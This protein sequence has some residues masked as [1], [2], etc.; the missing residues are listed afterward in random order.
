MNNLQLYLNDQLVDLSDDSPIALTFQIN[1]LADVKNQQG[2]TSNQ[3]KVPLTQNN[4]RILGFPDEV[5]FTNN[6]PYQQYA[7]KIVQDGLEIV[8]YGIG[9]LNSVDSNTASITILSGNVDFFDAIDQKIFDMGDSTSVATNKG[10]SLPWK[11]YD[12]AWTLQNVVSSQGKTDGWIWPVI[13]Y[14]NLGYN[15]SANPVTVDVRNLR[16]GFFLKTAL[17]LIT[18]NAGYT[19]NP[20]SSLL[21]DPLYEGLIVQFANDSFEHGTDYQN[22]NTNFSCSVSTGSDLVVT[23]SR[24]YHGTVPFS[25][26]VYGGNYFDHGRNYYTAPENISV[27][28]TLVFSAVIEGDPTSQNS[29]GQP[30]GVEVRLHR[31]SAGQLYTLTSTTVDLS[32]NPPLISKHHARY[33]KD[34]VKL[35]YEIVLSKGDNIYVEY[36]VNNRSAGTVTI[37]YGTTLTVTSKNQGI[38]YG[39]MVQCERIFPDINQKDLLKDMLQRFGIICQA[40]NTGKVITFAS[41][42]DIVSNIPIAKDWTSKCLDQGKSI[43][44]QL[45]NYAQINYMKYKQ[46]DNVLPLG[47]ADTQINIA[48]QTL[49]ATTE[50]FTSQFAGTLNRAFI[51]GSAAQINKVDVSSDPSATDFTIGTQ[52]RILI[53]EKLNLLGTGKTVRFTDGISHVDVN[54]SISVPYFS[55][56]NGTYDLRFNALRLKYYAELEK[57]LKQTKKVVRYFLLTPR[58]ILELDLL[59]PVYLQQDNA[60]YYINKIDSWQKGKATKVELILLG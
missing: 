52:P 19:I 25:M 40:D 56:N 36:N 60:Y 38:L 11:A 29:N 53:D 34:N 1:N 39:Q 7:A 20:Q 47:F 30:L 43:S 45:G 10:A 58:D 13:D 50:L 51:G 33:E 2:N 32:N 31:I 23:P 9:E 17:Q 35:S 28:I 27:T 37:K 3:F 46:D 44:F 42:R 6:L 59:V 49:P 4:R 21:S 8:P 54:D 22:G 12:H 26:N 55:K 5:A 41:L 48:D 18:Q 16:P 15:A 24:I 14:G 57:I